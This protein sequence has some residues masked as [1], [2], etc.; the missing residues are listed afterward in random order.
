N[1]GMHARLFVGPPQPV[2]TLA[3]LAS[4]TLD[5]YRDGKRVDAG[6]GSNAL[7]S[8]VAAVAHLIEVLAAGKRAPLAAGELVTTGTI[9]AALPVRP[10]ETWRTEIS[11]IALPSLEI[12]FSD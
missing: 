2:T 3:A 7:D 8:P 5:L 9:T 1:C 6:K 12:R 4:F 10:G 11:G